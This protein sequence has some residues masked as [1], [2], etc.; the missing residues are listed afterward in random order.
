MSDIWAKIEGLSGQKLETLSRKK[1]FT[2]TEVKN[3]TVYFVPGDG[4]GTSRF[5]P[6]EVFER[7]A[8]QDW[9]RT[10]LT[11]SR[12]KEEYPS[13]FNSSYIAAILKKVT[14]P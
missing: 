9:A 12:V 1:V 6:R 3:S 2:I 4:A 11:P 10:D 7:M 14:E 13:S 8:A 5:E